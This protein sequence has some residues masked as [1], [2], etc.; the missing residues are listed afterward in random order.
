[1]DVAAADSARRHL[2]Q[3]FRGAAAWHWQMFESESPVFG[4]NQ[5]V[6]NVR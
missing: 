5:S 1:M 4:Q 3:N 6:H 2:D